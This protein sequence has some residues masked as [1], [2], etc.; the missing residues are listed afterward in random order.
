MGEQNAGCVEDEERGEYQ[1]CVEGDLRLTA[2][3]IA[4]RALH[5]RDD[6][7]AEEKEEEQLYPTS[8]VASVT[9]TPT[10]AAW[11]TSPRSA[12][13]IVAAARQVST[14]RF[15]PPIPS[16]SPATTVVRTRN[17][18]SRSSSA[19]VRAFERSCA[20]RLSVVVGVFCEPRGPG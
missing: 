14:S 9:N 8:A 16:R 10:S 13:T 17:R 4:L 5:E 6:A 18:L 12:V 19:C 11:F 7:V 15:G 2:S 1:E 20:V 3:D